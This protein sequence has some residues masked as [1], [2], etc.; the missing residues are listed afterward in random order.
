[1]K[2]VY[3]IHS[4][5]FD[6]KTEL[7]QKLRKSSLNKK[8]NFIL[9]HEFSD[10]QYDSETLMRTQKDLEILIDLSRVSEGS[11]FEHALA[12]GIEIP[13]TGI[14]KKGS[15]IKK[16]RELACNHFFLYDEIEDIFPYLA[17]AFKV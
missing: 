11:T 10:N 13:I 9:P 6:Y 3:V 7:Y 17:R 14:A 16:Y 12:K 1:M 4:T 5:H 8:V 2:T 15:N